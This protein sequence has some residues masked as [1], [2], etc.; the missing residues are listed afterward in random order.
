[1]REFSTNN[2]TLDE[3]K[4]AAFE[5]L[6]LNPGCEQ[7]DWAQI[8][9]KQYGTEVVDAYGKDPAEHI[10]IGYCEEIGYFATGVKLDN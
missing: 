4:A 2:E 1:M 7:S 3:L 8:L 6:R 5:V 9:V 10:C